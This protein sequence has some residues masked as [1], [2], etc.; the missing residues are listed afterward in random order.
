MGA[1]SVKSEKEK[2]LMR[3]IIAF[4]ASGALARALAKRKLQPRPWPWET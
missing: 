4:L 2:T 3:G 1:L